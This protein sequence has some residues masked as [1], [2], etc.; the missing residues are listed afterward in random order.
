[1]QVP[2]PHRVAGDQNAFAK[3]SHH[4]ES[5]GALLRSSIVDRSEW[6]MGLHLAAA[7]SVHA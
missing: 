1:V 7:I 4:T 5:P 2:A 6:H 3:A